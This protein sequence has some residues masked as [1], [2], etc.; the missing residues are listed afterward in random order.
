[1]ARGP[2]QPSACSINKFHWNT[3]MLTCLC[4]VCGCFLP[5][6]AELSSCEET[7]C[8]QSLKYIY[9]L[10]LYR[11]ELPGPAQNHNLSPRTL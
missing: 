8:P 3:A 4:I 9:H 11:E 7:A 10:A 2:A 5:T 1:M 6:M